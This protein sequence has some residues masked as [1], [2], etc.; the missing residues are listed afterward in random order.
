MRGLFAVGLLAVALGGCEMGWDLDGT[1]NATTVTN[2][3]R[4]LLVYLVQGKTL[5]ASKRPPDGTYQL[6]A[7]AGPIPTDLLPFHLSELGCPAGQVMVLAWSPRM[8]TAVAPN[9]STSPSFAPMTGDLVVWSDVRHPYCGYG[10]NPESINVV[11][12]DADSE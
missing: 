4:S 9:T 8:M 7:Q 10:T 12:T 1:V 11:M 3:S 6:L 2:K 5:D